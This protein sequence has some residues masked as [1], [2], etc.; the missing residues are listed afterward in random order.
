MVLEIDINDH[1]LSAEEINYERT[2]YKKTLTI[3]VSILK[4]TLTHKLWSRNK[5]TFN[6]VINF[7]REPNT[8]YNVVQK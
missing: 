7:C 8:E 5:N 4:Q 1:L 2:N 6:D 3:K